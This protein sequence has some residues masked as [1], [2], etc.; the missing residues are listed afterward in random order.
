MFATFISDIEKLP[1][2]KE[3]NIALYQVNDFVRMYKTFFYNHYARCLKDIL[4]HSIEGTPENTSTFS[5]WYLGVTDP[6]KK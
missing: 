1:I 2:P 3:R 6:D 4:P 5:Q